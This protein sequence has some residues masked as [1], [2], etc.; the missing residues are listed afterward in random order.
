MHSLAP[1]LTLIL[2]LTQTLNHLANKP[3]QTT[4]ALFGPMYPTTAQLTIN[5]YVLFI[6]ENHVIENDFR[7]SD[8]VKE[9][10]AQ[11]KLL[12]VIKRLTT[13]LRHM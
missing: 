2:T 4:S 5:I 12:V 9:V 8:Q 13:S 3:Q 1:A 11:V 10:N 6:L 7:S